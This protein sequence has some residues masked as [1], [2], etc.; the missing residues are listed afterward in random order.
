MIYDYGGLNSYKKQEN[1]LNFEEFFGNSAWKTREFTKDL[2]SDGP[3]SICG[4]YPL[5]MS[6]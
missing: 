1:W 4:H 3:G 2:G 6:K 5:V